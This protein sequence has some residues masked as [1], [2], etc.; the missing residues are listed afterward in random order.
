MAIKKVLIVGGGIGG[1]SAAIGLTKAGVEVDIVEINEKWT[2]YHVG[3]IVQAN[4]I[5][6]MKELGIADR[7][8]AAGFPYRGVE[9][10]E[11]DGSVIS[12]VQGP[13]IAGDEY[14]SDLGMARPALH[15]ILTS[16]VRATSADIRLGVTF[17][18]MDQHDDFVR[19]SFTDGTVKDYDLVIG[20]DGVYSKVRET[21]FG[22]D[23]KPQ[24]TGQGVWR[25][26]VPRPKGLD[27]AALYKGSLGKAGYVPLTP[28]TMYILLVWAE[29]GNP[30]MERDKLDVLLRDRLAE[31]GGHVGHARDNYINDPTQVV[32][33][34]LEVL[35][36]PP[37][38]NKGRVLLI[39]DA[40]H[41]TT[42]HL[43]NG[44]S[45]A[46]EDAIVLAELVARDLPLDDMFA[47]FMKRRYERCKFIWESSVMVGNW[48]ITKDPTADHPALRRKMLEVMALPI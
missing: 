5:R 38:W 13:R 15:E 28:E 45:Q 39:G 33:R 11:A 12:H 7:A 10:C 40:A 24:F 14:P 23:L 17:T 27:T 16:T 34:P 35:L 18:D 43:G 1:L 6:A 8:V 36:M 30:K 47:E 42:P 31:F 32:Y 3:I 4:F 22:T 2:V 20:A 41:A 21:I 46:V 9:M 29:P 48:E 25:Y 19:V 26:N 37:P 44:A